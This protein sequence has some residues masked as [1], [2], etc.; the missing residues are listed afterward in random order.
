MPT[1]VTNCLMRPE[2][3][4]EKYFVDTARSLGY[5]QYKF[6]AGETGVPDRILIGNNKTVFVELKA[7]NGVL[8]ER[9]KLIHKQ[10][11]ARGGTVFTPFSKQEIDEIFDFMQ[12]NIAQE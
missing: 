8:S 2:A 9:Q 5:L 3:K 12:R 6:T 1:G 7:L 4:L 10:I 11:R